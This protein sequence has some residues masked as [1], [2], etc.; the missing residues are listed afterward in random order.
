MLRPLKTRLVKLL[1]LSEL[2]YYRRTGRRLTSLD[3][4]FYHFGPYAFS[5]AQYIGDPDIDTLPFEL[6]SL[7]GPESESLGTGVEHDV[8]VTV[9][10]VVHTWGGAD[11]NALLDYVYFETEPMASARRGDSLDFSSVVPAPAPR[12]LVVKL[13]EKKIDELR[14]KLAARSPWYA[15]LRVRTVGPDDL[16]AN[17]R[18]WDSDRTPI[19]HQG[20]CKIDPT[21]LVAPDEE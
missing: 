21:K 9:A 16:F 2:E 15:Q 13:D 11:L 14:K 1:Y 12:R 17:L 8:N 20:E 18:E 4:K 10:D 19:L 7:A 3:W 5:L 6:P